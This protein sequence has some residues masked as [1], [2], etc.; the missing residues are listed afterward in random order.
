MTNIEGNAIGF[1]HYGSVEVLEERLVKVAMSDL[2]DVIIKIERAGINPVDTM[3]RSGAMSGGRPLDHFW[4]PGSE[5][6]GEVVAMKQPVEGLAIGDKV[7]GKPGR[8]GYA[9]YVALSHQNVFKIP[10]GMSLDEAAGFSGTASTAYWGLHGGF[11]DIQPNQT[12]AVI[13]ASGSVGSYLVQL[14]KAFDVTIIAAASERN[15]AYVLGLG[16]DIFIDYSDSEQVAKYA[17]QA[18]FVIDASLFN[19]GEKTALTLAKQHATYMGMT[20]LPDPSLRPDVKRVFLSRTAEMTNSIA[21]PAL[22]SFYQQYGLTIKNGYVLP[23]TLEGAKEAH[24]MIEENRQ[25][26]KI[27]LSREA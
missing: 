1:D 9:E 17:G 6:Q 10:E 25:P 14:L 20:T 7:I 12:I 2:H 4:I 11:Y 23:F 8:G 5:V 27:I 16:A 18:D 3:F 24:Q 26:G 13:G 15:R 21:M 19:R 22:F